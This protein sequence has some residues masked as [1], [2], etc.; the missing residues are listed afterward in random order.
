MLFWPIVIAIG[1]G[2]A[3][4]YYDRNVK[5]FA[6]QHTCE[7][8]LPALERN[9]KRAKEF[10]TALRQAAGEQMPKVVFK[11]ACVNKQPQQFQR[12]LQDQGEK[13]GIEI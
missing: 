4:V 12:D 13:A 1:P 9:A 7:R 11:A 3:A 6:N 8:T 5:S 10:M 2:F